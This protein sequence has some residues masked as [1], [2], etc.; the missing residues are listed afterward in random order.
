MVEDGAEARRPNQ[1]EIRQG[2][3]R[4]LPSSR[5]FM[6]SSLTFKSSIHFEFILMYVIEG[7]LVLFFAR[8]CPVFPT[9]F[10]E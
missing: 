1:T 8:I 4:L 2:A 3:K 5:I 7:G 9:P 6:I 10:I